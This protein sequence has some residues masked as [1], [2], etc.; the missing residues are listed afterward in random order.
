MKA[1]NINKPRHDKLINCT[2]SVGFDQHSRNR[3]RLIRILSRCSGIFSL[4]I[5]N[6]NQN[7][8]LKS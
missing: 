6:G 7:A 4:Y 2:Q 5:L 3:L 8:L 1:I